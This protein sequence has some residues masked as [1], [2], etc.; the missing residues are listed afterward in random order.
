MNDKKNINVDYNCP[1]C[2]EILEIP[3]EI[4]VGTELKCPECGNEFKLV[5]SEEKKIVPKDNK[6]NAI[7]TH[8]ILV[9]FGWLLFVGAVGSS[10]NENIQMDSKIIFTCFYILAYGFIKR[11][12]T[13]NWRFT[14][15]KIAGYVIL[16]FMGLCFMVPVTHYNS[17][18]EREK[19]KNDKQVAVKA[20][21]D[22][23]ERELNKI[24]KKK[25]NTFKGYH[26]GL[27]Q[28]IED[29]MNDPKS[30]EHIK[31]SYKQRADGT[32]HIVMK[33][34]AKNAFGAL[35]LCNSSAILD[36]KGDIIEVH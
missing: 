20:E 2:N 29:R 24:I 6:K 27:K 23:Q 9:F 11:G 12:I 19:Q 35:I 31:T 8:K 7:K 28:H 30:F 10:R 21:A 13:K 26:I 15:P 3:L 14:G 25:F 33:Y 34:R 18:S 5:E 17:L 16:L 32:I 1:V 36:S 4:L 22:R